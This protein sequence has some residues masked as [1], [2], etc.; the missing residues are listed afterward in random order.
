MSLVQ[1]ALTPSL[2]DFG[3]ILGLTL[4]RNSGPAACRRTC[5]RPGRSDNRMWPALW[6]HGSRQMEGS[7]LLLRIPFPLHHRH[8]ARRIQVHSG[9][10]LIKPA[11]LSRNGHVQAMSETVSYVNR[12]RAFMPPGTCPPSSRARCGSV[13]VGYLASPAPPRKLA[14]IQDLALNTV[15]R[16]LR[17]WK[18]S[19]R[20]PRFG[21]SPPEPSWSMSTP[22]KL[23]SHGLSAQDV[24]SA[25]AN[26]EN[27]CPLK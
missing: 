3:V 21:G 18:V 24:V 1:F 27:H 5:S 17:P 23:Q 19:P 13:P 12:A 20:L 2:Y 11:I 25:I 7:D 6:R 9:A 4:G 15:V 16:C 22:A 14:R 8:R 26:A 10:A